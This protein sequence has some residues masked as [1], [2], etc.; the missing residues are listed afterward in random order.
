METSQET[1]SDSNNFYNQLINKSFQGNSVGDGEIIDIVTDYYWTQNKPNAVENKLA[2]VPFLYA[3]EYKQKLGVTASNLFNTVYALGDSVGSIGTHAKNTLSGIFD[4][5]SGT[6]GEIFGEQN[7]GNKQKEENKENKENKGLTQDLT[8]AKTAVNEIVNRTEQNKETI[9]GI[10]SGNSFL[11]TKLLSPYQHLYALES[12][13]KSYCFPF[14]TEG[15]ASWSVSNSFG[16]NGS[17]GLLSKAISTTMDALVGGV[18]DFAG[19]IQDVANALNEHKKEGFT[20]YNIE[21][22]K[23]F[24]FPSGGKVVSVRFPLFN[25]VKKD[26]WKDNY[27]FII[28]FGTRN[29]LYRKNNVQYYPPLFYD[30]SIPGYG[31]MPLS[32]VKSFTV[33]PVGMTR[34]LPYN[35]KDIFGTDTN[36]SSVIV[37]EAWVV[38]I[39]FES[40]IAESSNQFLSSL[41]DLKINATL[42]YNDR[43]AT[44]KY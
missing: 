1:S 24:S 38:N 43:N 12:T 31:R 8:N 35:I 30:I 4:K 36:T 37:P 10:Y 33:K 6:L 11:K 3:T 34:I 18:V 22:A 39:E 20:M 16:S 17:M 28:L 5:L 44:L 41:I 27:R 7:E 15:A 29:M 19:D 32:F 13:N 25:T 40:L 14:F 23:A 21:K 9:G 2:E 26:A 42:N